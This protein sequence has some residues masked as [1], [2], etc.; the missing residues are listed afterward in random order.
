MY[1]TQT[2]ENPGQHHPD[3]TPGFRP[4]AHLIELPVDK[5]HEGQHVQH[6]DAHGTAALV[7]GGG[8]GLLQHPQHMCFGPST[9]G[10][11]AQLWTTLMESTDNQTEPSS[12][13]TTWARGLVIRKGQP[14][15]SF[16]DFGGPERKA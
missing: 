14:P 12:W 15:H 2:G 9:I 3:H 7:P 11:E 16:C 10:R 8:A 1:K 4:S 6:L 5:Q 13:T